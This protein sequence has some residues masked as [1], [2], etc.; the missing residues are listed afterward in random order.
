MYQISPYM[1][2]ARK[3]A[4]IKTPADFKGKVLGSVGDNN[5]ARITYRALMGQFGVTDSQVTQK[6]LDFDIVKD[7]QTHASDTI[8]GYRT[9]ETYLLDKNGLAY[10]PIYPEQYGFELYGDLIVANSDWVKQNPDIAR[11]FVQ[12]TM[13]GWDYAT[14][15]EQE[16]VAIVM[17][18]AQGDFHDVAYENYI[19][20]NSIP[21]IRPG[22]I[23]QLGGQQFIP[24][25][26]AYQALRASNTITNTVD[27]S[28]LYTNDFL[29]K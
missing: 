16:T 22:G 12:A 5:Q 10:T 25:N 8:D 6:P 13:K 1:F 11:K 29:A 15:H 18:H 14:K 28:T 19:L 17:N 27:V 26:R 23:K 20:H 21:L 24:W 3:D 2:M 9:N 7:Y 4:N